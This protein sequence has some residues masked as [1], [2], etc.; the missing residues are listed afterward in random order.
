MRADKNLDFEKRFKLKITFFYPLKICEIRDYPRL[1]FSVFL[2]RIYLYRIKNPKKNINQ[3][4]N[5]KISGTAVISRRQPRF[6]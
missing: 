1:K 6:A 5:I 4:K 2:F 3:N